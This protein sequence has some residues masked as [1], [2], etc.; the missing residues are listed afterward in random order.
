MER[1]IS[2]NEIKELTNLHCVVAVPMVSPLESLVVVTI[3]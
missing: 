2:F 3:E 1:R